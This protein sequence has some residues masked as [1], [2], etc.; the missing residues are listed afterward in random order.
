MELESA[1]LQEFFQ[2]DV[3]FVGDVF[4][5][6]QTAILHL[7]FAINPDQR[8]RGHGS[9]QSILLQLS[10]HLNHLKPK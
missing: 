10:V 5:K 1:E 3:G 2:V 8:L 7:I 4:T 9:V 6:D